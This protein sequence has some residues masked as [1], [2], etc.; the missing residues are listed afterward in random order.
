MS[1]TTPR[2]GPRRKPRVAAPPLAGP[3]TSF[4]VAALF[5]LLFP[6]FPRGGELLFTEQITISSLMLVAATYAIS[7]SASSRYVLSW[8]MGIT[9]GLV[10]SALFGWCM[11]IGDQR[12]GPAY[13][14]GA[15]AVAGSGWLWAGMVGIGVVL[16]MHAGERFARHVKEK[17]PFPEFLRR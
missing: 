3:W 15:G 6:L 9:V 7:L 5:L 11:G 14:L 1:T 12:I 16:V 10:F 17:E 2:G 8:A 13:R 4:A